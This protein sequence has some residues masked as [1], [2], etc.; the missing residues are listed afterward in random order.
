MTTDPGLAQ[1]DLETAAI[2][3]QCAF[4]AGMTGNGTSR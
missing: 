4:E 2:I 3:A 1:T